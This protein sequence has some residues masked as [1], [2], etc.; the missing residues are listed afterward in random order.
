MS[1]LET[2]QLIIKSGGLEAPV[3][4]EM[5]KFF[6]ESSRKNLIVILKRAGKCSVLTLCAI[7]LLFFVKKMGIS[8][9]IAK[10]YVVLTVGTSLVAGTVTAAAVVTAKTVIERHRRPAVVHETV[11]PAAV[12]E[13]QAKEELPPLKKLHLKYGHVEKVQL[14]DGTVLEGTIRSRAS[15][16]DL[17]TPEGV[18]NISP[19]DILSVEYIS[20]DTR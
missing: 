2:I 11:V 20:P 7:N 1:N 17:V 14:K 4:P 9:T 8:L 16:I 6:L 19:D 18:L 5:R 10:A 13:P 12:K 15:G 3:P